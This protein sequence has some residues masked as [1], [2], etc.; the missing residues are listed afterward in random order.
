MVMTSS[1][2]SPL[3]LLTTPLLPLQKPDSVPGARKRASSSSEGVTP[4]KRKLSP[5]RF[6]SGAGQGS[7][8]DKK[9]DRSL[10][11]L[12]KGRFSKDISNDDFEQSQNGRGYRGRGRGSR[13]GRYRRGSW[14]DN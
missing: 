8:S 7:K 1:T 6:E 5:I 2:Y 13:R 4:P 3:L 11:E 12:P 14:R 9:Q 10:Y